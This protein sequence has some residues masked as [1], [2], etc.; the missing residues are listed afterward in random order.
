ML[1]DPKLKLSAAAACDP[2]INCGEM[3]H[4]LFVAELV[5]RVLLVRYV[6]DYQQRGTWRKHH[7]KI[8]RC[9]CSV[10]ARFGP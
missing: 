10:G 2:G 5:I 3:P 4:I 6:P 1:A 9:H 7:E 8:A